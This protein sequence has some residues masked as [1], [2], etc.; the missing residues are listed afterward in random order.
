MNALKTQAS[1]L[2]ELAR[3]AYK[4]YPA[5]TLSYA[6]AGVAFVAAQLGT[7]SVDQASLLEALKY[8]A[9]ILLAGEATH[10]K[11]SPVS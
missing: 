5:R 6:A 10:R 7:G 2:L 1:K 11:V 3:E 8:M 4:R 9:P